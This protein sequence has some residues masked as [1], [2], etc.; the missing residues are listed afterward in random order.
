VSEPPVVWIIDAEQWP[1]ALLRAELIEVGYEAIG[2]V[3]LGHAVAAL[4]LGAAAYPAPRAIVIDLHDQ[5]AT[6]DTLARLASSGAPLIAVGGGVDL[7]E[8]AVASLRWT[9]VLRRPVT[10]G[11]I[12]DT[13]AKHVPVGRQSV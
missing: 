5:G 9:A 6:A 11:E 13:V 10:L 1:R 8:P 7:A 2:F 12:R 3:R 4:A